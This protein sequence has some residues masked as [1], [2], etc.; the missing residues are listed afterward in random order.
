MHFSHGFEDESAGAHDQMDNFS[1]STT[2][3]DSYFE[4]LT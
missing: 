4:A 3:N 1:L 2:V